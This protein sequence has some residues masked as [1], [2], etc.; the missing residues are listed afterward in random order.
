VTT[1]ATA[2]KRTKSSISIP[3]YA[4]VKKASTVLTA[5]AEF[6]LK[7]TTT[8]KIFNGALELILVDPIRFSSMVSANV[9]L[10]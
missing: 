6:A 7:D 5:N 10:D 3:V 1:T 9:N 4:I 2:A 8:M